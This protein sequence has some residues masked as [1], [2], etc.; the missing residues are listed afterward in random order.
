MQ[1]K[2]PANLSSSLLA[3]KGQANPSP[4]GR[5]SSVPA[6]TFVAHPANANDRV[7]PAPLPVHEE[8]RDDADEFD[9]SAQAKRPVGEG[10]R[11]AMTVRLDHETHRRLRLLSAH[12]NKSSQE[13]FTEALESYMKRMS[14]RIPGDGCACLVNPPSIE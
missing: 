6:A 13:I 2:G 4:S 7:V 10:A 9:A 14:A 11:I 1:T 8:P 12:T 5:Y 3:R